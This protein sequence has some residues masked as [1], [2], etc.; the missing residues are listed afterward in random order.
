M[1]RIAAVIG[2]LGGIAGILLG[3][4]LQAHADVNDFTITQ[5]DITYNLSRD[6]ENRSVLQTTETITAV[7]PESDQNHGLERAIPRVYDGHSTSIT[8]D[9]VTKPD[10]SP[11]PYS[12][13]TSGDM[14]L[15]RIG[16]P[17]TYVHGMQTVKLVYHQRDVTKFFENTD[18][19][20]WYW[21]TNGTDWRVPITALNITVNL[22]KEV[23]DALPA[24]PRCYSGKMGSSTACVMTKESDTVYR[25]NAT[26]LKAG[27]NITVAYGFQPG[28]F[29]PYQKSIWETLGEVWAVALFVTGIVGTGVFIALT[30]AYY[31]RTNRQS[32]LAVRP[33]QYLPPKETSVLVSAQLYPVRGSA[34]TGQLI[35]LAVRHKLRIIE[36]G[37]KS[38]WTGMASYDIEILADLKDEPSE[39]QEI[40]SDMNQ[41]TLPAIGSRIA[42][43]KLS[44]DTKYQART[45]DDL[46]NLKFLSENVY[47]LRAKSPQT[48][49]FFYGWAIGLLI[50]AVLT[51]SPFMAFYAG[52]TALYGYTIRPLTD[53]GLALRRYLYGLAEYIK[54]SEVRRLEMFQAPDTAQKIGE[55]IDV[56]NPG[57]IVKLY[58]RV[59]PYA[60]IFG[61]EKQWSKQLGELY[62][63]AQTD[64]SWYSGMNGFSAVAFASSLSAFSTASSYAGSSSSSSS[65][66]SSG[67][68]SSGGGG[69]GGGGGGW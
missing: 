36:V 27:E 8:I 22:S 62:G 55:S 39:V 16:D 65:G 17:D 10:G 38:V 48:S 41:G 52:M 6:A 4:P 69:G 50:V 26:D 23:A 11:W 7:F 51:L 1:K 59:L 43:K 3:V 19:T 45:Y 14:M 61:Y 63:K 20:E 54:A 21:D 18:R 67:G 68:G 33:V 37:K 46:K 56:K 44:K 29:Q 2:M 24:G 25:V 66:G 30:V 35:D 5:Y 28:T 64:P 53:K 9:S 58:E 34:F 40:L 47:K 49:R 13:S 15:L 12:T 32:E 60:I 57:Q 31:R 42:L